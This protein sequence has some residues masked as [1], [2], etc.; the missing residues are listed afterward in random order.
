ML[1]RTGV[2]WLTLI[3]SVGMTQ[4]GFAAETNET[5]PLEEVIVSGFRQSHANAVK[6]KREAVGVTDSISAEGLGRFPD[7]NVGEALQRV[8]GIQ[9]NREAES[10]NATINLRGLPGTYA[11]VTINGVNFADPVLDEATPLGAFNSD[12]FTAIAVIKSPSAADQPG[13]IS[14]NI[15]LQIQPALA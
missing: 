1:K 5:A 2:V 4:S 6:A 7:L 12:V 14:G 9:I 10:R 13:G 8:P 3:S 11:R 15:D